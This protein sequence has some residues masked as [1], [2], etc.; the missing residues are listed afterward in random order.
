MAI[1]RDRLRQ[2]LPVKIE[3]VPL[4]EFGAGE[5]VFIHG[6]TAKEKN[7]HDARIWNADFDGI[8]TGMVKIQKQCMLIQCLR[9][10]HGQRILQ[11]EDVEA[12][13]EW[14]ADTFNN[15]FDECNKLCGGTGDS[16]TKD[17]LE[18][19]AKNSQETETD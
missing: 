1:S 2:G 16:M 18:L 3:R 6:M 12:L 15:L 4:E 5:H 8:N 19:A 7:A 10:E 13:G 14:P 11:G 17:S 9:D